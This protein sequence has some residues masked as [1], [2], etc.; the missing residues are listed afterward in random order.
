MN[1]VAFA[2]CVLPFLA[3]CSG[4]ELV[5]LHLTVLADGSA[6]ITAK[7]L[8]ESPT[9]SP[10]EVMSK[11]VAW[12]RRAALVYS[13]GNVASL[14]DL[15]FG[16]DSLQIKEKLDAQKLTILIK[17]GP[18]AGWVNCLVPAKQK[19]QEMTAVYDPNEK[20]RNGANASE[21]AKALGD[22]LRIELVLPSDVSAS[23]VLRTARG[24][25]AGKERT[26][27]Y[28]IIPADTAREKGDTIEWTVTWTE[29]PPR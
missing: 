9:P 6:T 13:Q 11:G 7:A 8:V 12:N 23:S 1:Q 17:P 4:S 18:T 15:G 24:V 2:L 22:T 10:A 5:G 20:P 14:K 27:A 19:Q 26:R 21:K 16:D 3:A 29:Q 28:L 25:E